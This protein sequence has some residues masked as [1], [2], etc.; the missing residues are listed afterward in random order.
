MNRKWTDWQACAKRLA[1]ADEAV[2]PLNGPINEVP[3]HGVSSADA[4]GQITQLSEKVG[5]L[6][7]ADGVDSSGGNDA[8]RHGD[9]LA[10]EGHVMQRGGLIGVSVDKG[11][12]AV[13][14]VHGQRPI[15]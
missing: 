6:A 7:G 14:G 11:K 4:G 2:H 15:E 13:G 8:V 10:V 1:V 9:S 3:G 12:E 5:R